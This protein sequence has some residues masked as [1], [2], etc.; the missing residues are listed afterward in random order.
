MTRGKGYGNVY[1]RTAIMAVV[2]GT[3]S[4]IT[5]GKFA[6][7]AESGAFVHLFNAE[8]VVSK[9]FLKQGAQQAGSKG[10]E[11]IAKSLNTNK[12][13]ENI[14]KDAGAGVVGGAIGGTI[15]FGFPIGTIGGAIFGLAGGLVTG[16]AK[17]SF[18]V[19]QY[20]DD[21]VTKVDDYIFNCSC[22]EPRGHK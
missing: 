13:V 5:G 19:N 16:A 14:S 7:G 15:V 1:S 17:E 20:V 21:T 10:A 18:G 3:T 8:G 4:V 6:N 12:A 22:G 9:F 11:E 2:G